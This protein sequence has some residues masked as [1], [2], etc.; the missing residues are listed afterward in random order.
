MKKVLSFVFAMIMAVGFCACG[1]EA[2]SGEFNTTVSKKTVVSNVIP[3]QDAEVS[4]ITDELKNFLNGYALGK[5]LT[6]A[7]QGDKELA[8]SVTLSWECDAANNGFTVIYTTNKDFSDAVQEH[9]N[10][11]KLE[12]EGLF[13][14][15][16][17]Y[18][19]IVTHMDSGDNYSPVY[20]FVTADTP[21]ILLTSIANARDIGGYLTEDGKFRVKQGMIYRGIQ[22][23][24][25][26]GSSKTRLVEKYGIKTDLDFRSSKDTAFTGTGTPLGDPVQYINAQILD[27]HW[28]IQRPEEMKKAIETLAQAE[29]YPIYLHC[30]AG[31]DRTGTLCYLLG[32][33]LGVPE[34][35]LFADYE[36]TYL[37]RV[38]YDAGD[39]TGHDRFLQFLDVFYHFDGVGIQQKAESYLKSVGITDEQIQDIRDIMLIAVE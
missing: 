37:S 23:E 10:K 35:K 4:L 22:L 19:Q 14:A 17:Y 21:R 9:T 38:S 12:L 16:T 8:Q 32:A 29:N 24:N 34:E 18:W 5:G 3:A 30:A 1:G 31:R 2:D 6:V 27:Y 28:N 15:T 13:V 11:K 33:L 25:A 20:T 39:T 36:M 7:G 26:S